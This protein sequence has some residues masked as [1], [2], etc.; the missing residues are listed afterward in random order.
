MEVSKMTAEASSLPKSGSLKERLAR[1]VGAEHVK[2]Q[3]DQL[4]GYFPAPA[5]TSGLLAV[6]PAETGEVQEIMRVASE[7]GVVVR[8][9]ND[10]RLRDSDAGQ[11]GIVL[12]FQRMRAVERLD[13]R[14][15]LAHVQRGLTFVELKKVLD[16]QDLKIATPIGATS[17][18][19]LCNF[20]NR[21]PL[22]K[23]TFYPEVNVFTMQVV[24]ADG[25]LFRTGSHALSEK[26]DLREDGGPSLSRWFF[27]SDDIFGVITRAT[28][29][30]YP[31]TECREA[32]LFGF[33]TLE[34]AARVLRNV[35]RTEL[36]SEYLAANRRFLSS[37]LQEEKGRLPVW[38]VMVGFDGKAKLVAYQKERIKKIM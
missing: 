14:N 30:L 4:A 12:D 15:L 21:T 26:V 38:T 37:L 13:K 19:V 32:L 3:P 8:T 24:L 1:I 16:E 20:I 10:R 35:P 31:R 17:D 23:A 29:W 9:M 7:S 2:D 25:T 5:E 28:I 34:E 11:E 36:G 22:K 33:D 6:Q 18:S 27:G